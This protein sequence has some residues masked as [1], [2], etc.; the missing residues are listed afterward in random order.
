M[1]ENKAIENKTNG[2][3]M[4]LDE[5]YFLLEEAL[6]NRSII[7][8][9]DEEIEHIH[10]NKNTEDP[11]LQGLYYKHGIFGPINLKKAFKTF[12]LIDD[13]NIEYQG[14]KE[15]KTPIAA[16]V[17]NQLSLFHLGY[18]GVTKVDLELSDDYLQQSIRLGN[19]LAIEHQ[20]NEL[21]NDFA[22]NASNFNKNDNSTSDDY[23]IPPDIDKLRRATELF[24]RAKSLGSKTAIFDLIDCY[25]YKSDYGLMFMAY[26][27][28]INVNKYYNYLE[29]CSI[30]FKKLN[31]N[32]RK[33]Y[34]T[35]FLELLLNGCS[36]HERKMVI[37][38]HIKLFDVNILNE[39]LYEQGLS[40]KL[41]ENILENLLFVFNKDLLLYT[42]YMTKLFKAFGSVKIVKKI[43]N[44]D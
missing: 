38:E 12:D 15:M 18:Q 39:I 2:N 14:W 34:R 19:R 43:L 28:L 42:K 25:K 7:S 26:H 13:G 44:I 37:L 9:G 24:E 40:E 36:C 29:R 11:Y 23:I 31:E 4:P 27:E 30:E 1:N 3:E 8:E 35:Q 16:F 22:G 20:A 33:I 17:T 41:N 5:F 6:N 32:C 10:L 21:L